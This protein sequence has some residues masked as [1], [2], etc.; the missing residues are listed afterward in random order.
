MST[1]FDFYGFVIYS[2]GSG[3]TKIDFPSHTSVSVARRDQY[4][5]SVRSEFSI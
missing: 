1:M 5:N 3:W 4:V 2:V